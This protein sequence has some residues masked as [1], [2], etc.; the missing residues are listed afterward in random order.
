VLAWIG[1][2]THTF[3]EGSD[4]GQ[5]WF[6]ALILLTAAPTFALLALRLRVGRA[7]R[8]QAG[9]RSSRAGEPRPALGESG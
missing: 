1:G 2:L 3:T 8:S 7:R 9:A 6:I 4:A 5:V